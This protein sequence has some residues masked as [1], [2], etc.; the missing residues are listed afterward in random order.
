MEK[1]QVR[2]LVLDVVKPQEPSIVEYATKLSSVEGNEGVNVSLIEVDKRVENVRI[3]IQ[4]KEIDVDKT[5]E[6]IESLGGAIHSI[7][8]VASGAEMIGHAVTLE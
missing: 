7:D 4:G 8:E 1:V 5:F 2:K 3:T 6:A